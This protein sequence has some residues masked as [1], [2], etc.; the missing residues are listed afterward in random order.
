MNDLT[1]L[2]ALELFEGVDRGD[3]TYAEIMAAALDRI[4]EVNPSVNAIVSLRDR[5]VLMKEAEAA[6]SQPKRTK[7]HGLPIAVKDLM[8]T[9][10]IRTTFGSPI[11]K[12]LVPAEDAVGASNIRASGMIIIGKTNTPEFGLGSHSYNPV[13]G[14]TRNPYDLSKSA[15]GSSGGASAALA[16]RMVPIADGSDMMGSLRNPAAWCNV[17]GLRPSVGLVPDGST[18]DLFLHQLATLGPMA[19]S[20]EDLALMLD[21]LAPNQ[22]GD[23]FF[24]G[25]SQTEEPCRI[26]WLGDWK[27]H[28]QIEGD[29]LEKCQTGAHVFEEMGHTIEAVQLDFDPNKLWM[30]WVRLR[31]VAMAAKMKLEYENPE[32]RKLLKPEMIYEIEAGRALSGQ[33][34]ADAVSARTDWFKYMTEIYQSYDA[35]AFPSAQVMPFRAELDWPKEI[36]GQNMSTYHNWMEIV[37]PTSLIGLPALNLPA[38][39]S[40]SGLPIGFQLMGARGSD[41]KLLSLGK[42][43]HEATLWPK[44]HPPKL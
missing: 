27:G 34:I 35:I 30:S 3:F 13:H 5:G 8:E 36:N 37:V 2:G 44:K 28:Y 31:N 43:Y 12:D 10:G 14:V 42:A 17:Y 41:A 6:A 20:I 18:G 16:A 1:E 21:I 29:I 22:S 32:T 24:D 4:E 25:L 38:G 7:L 26:G 19:R 15:G 11:Y 40:S 33:E 23:F 9:Q 39:F